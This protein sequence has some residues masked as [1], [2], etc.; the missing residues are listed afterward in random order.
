MHGL[1]FDSLANTSLP[2]LTLLSTRLP[3][4][5]SQPALIFNQPFVRNSQYTDPRYDLV[6]ALASA[7]AMTNKSTEDTVRLRENWM[8]CATAACWPL[9]GWWACEVLA[10]AT[11]AC[12]T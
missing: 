8:W 12:T 9:M 11:M 4:L 10:I 2:V 5:A 3:P 7:Q 6:E 1:T